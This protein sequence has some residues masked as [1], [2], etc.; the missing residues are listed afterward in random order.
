MHV[1]VFINYWIE[2]CTVKH[3]NLY[4]SDFTSACDSEQQVLSFCP[5]RVLSDKIPQNF[6]RD[7]NTESKKFREKKVVA[8]NIHI[9]W[10]LEWSFPLWK[11]ELYHIYLPFTFLQPWT[12]GWPASAVWRH[13]IWSTD[14]KVSGLGLT[15]PIA[16]H[17]ALYFFSCVMQNLSLSA[18][19]IRDLRL[20][21]LLIDIILSKHIG[22][23]CKISPFFILN[24]TLVLLL[25]EVQGNESAEPS[26]SSMIFPIT[27]EQGT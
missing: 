17:K 1:L 15:V 26:N 10:L 22:F 18:R 2:K 21:K 9:M 14:N 11:F 27:E 4:D 3:W 24:N 13:A 25:W 7:W 19:S 16:Y 8:V 6:E 20:K 12:W 23:P 5:L